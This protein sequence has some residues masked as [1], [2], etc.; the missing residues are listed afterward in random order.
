M[1]L[2][3]SFYSTIQYS[4]GL[5]RP[6][7]AVAASPVHEKMDLMMPPEYLNDFMVSSRHSSFSSRDHD[8]THKYHQPEFQSG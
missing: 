8:C 4:W 7:R 5:G 2:S 1:G 6:L 3:H